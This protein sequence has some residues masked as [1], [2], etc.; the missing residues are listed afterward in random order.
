M[1][2]P[3]GLAQGPGATW[4]ARRGS[5]TLSDGSAARGRFRWGEVASLG[6]ALTPPFGRFHHESSLEFNKVCMKSDDHE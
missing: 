4:S 6:S 3:E 5:A 2:V 1:A